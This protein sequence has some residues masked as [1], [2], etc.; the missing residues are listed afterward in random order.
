MCKD[1]AQLKIGVL[2]NNAGLSHELPER[3]GE[4]DAQRIRD[5]I[6][7][8]IVAVNEITYRLLPTLQKNKAAGRRALIL[9]I[10]SASGIAP[11]PYL[12]A[13]AASKSYLAAWSSALQHEY[14]SDC[15]DVDCP[16]PFFVVSNM[17]KR[18][19]P[20]A[21]IPSAETYVKASLAKAGHFDAPFAPYFLHGL[22]EFVI[23]S[24]PV[25]LTQML[26]AQNKAMHVDIRKRALKKAEREKATVAPTKK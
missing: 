5:I 4:A 22:M 26:V 14:R 8:N 11:T 6:N 25:A 16:L 12:A 21:A 9:N 23:R 10:G 1:L 24:V 2:V 18:S 13:Y 17:S 15:I 3:F 20:S 7:V 19:R